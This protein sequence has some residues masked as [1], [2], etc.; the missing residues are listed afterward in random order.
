MPIF[1]LNNFHADENLGENLF[2]LINREFS[3]Q[4]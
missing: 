4:W 3:F 2:F 1:K